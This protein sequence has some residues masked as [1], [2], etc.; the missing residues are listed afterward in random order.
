VAKFLLLS[1]LAALVVIPVLT[2]RGPNPYRALRNLI[3][4]I[5]GFNLF[6]LFAVRY[7]Y[8]HL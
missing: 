4:A 6:Y 3:L 8:P 1:I 2:A 5:V 7:L